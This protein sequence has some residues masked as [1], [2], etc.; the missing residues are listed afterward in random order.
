MQEVSIPK[1]ELPTLDTT[2]KYQHLIDEDNVPLPCPNDCSGGSGT[3]YR[4]VETNKLTER[5]FRPTVLVDRERKG[6]KRKVK[7]AHVCKMYAI[8]LYNTQDAANHT[9]NFLAEK[10]L[11]NWPHRFI[12]E[13]FLEEQ[14]GVASIVDAV[15]RQPKVDICG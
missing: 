3:A 13:G 14:D 5:D 9:F 15:C 8:S 6:T 2:L 12:A 10:F 1:S 7:N 4:F 11:N